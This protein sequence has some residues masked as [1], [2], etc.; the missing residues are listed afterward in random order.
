MSDKAPN[1]SI[2][3]EGFHFT[4]FTPKLSDTILKNPNM[5]KL[6]CRLKWKQKKN[7]KEI[8][9]KTI[10]VLWR[11]APQQMPRKHRSLEAYYAALWWKWWSVFSFY[12]VMEHRWNEIDRDKP[13]YSEKN[14]SQCHFVHHISN[15]GL[16]CKRPATNRLSHGTNIKHT[17]KIFYFYGFSETS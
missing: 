14:M 17:W 16:H 6:N 3:W 1:V 13:K 5:C 12:R 4:E 11:R 10:F 8:F 7:L 15:P 9:N 2:V